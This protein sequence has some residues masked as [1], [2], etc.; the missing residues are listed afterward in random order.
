[1]HPLAILFHLWLLFI[2]YLFLLYSCGSW[3]HFSLF[4]L[5][6]S[7]LLYLNDHFYLILFNVSRIFIV[8]SICLALPYLVSS[9][10]PYFQ[11]NKDTKIKIIYVYEA[12]AETGLP[13][14]QGAP[15]AQI[16]APDRI[17]ISQPVWGN[18]APMNFERWVESGRLKN[19]GNEMRTRRLKGWRG[20]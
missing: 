17:L 11:W 1:M 9:Q 8:D 4:S 19:K 10:F 7:N 6:Q 3:V 13:Q 18:K 15:H 14:S 5:I 2:I 12:G 20:I 16:P